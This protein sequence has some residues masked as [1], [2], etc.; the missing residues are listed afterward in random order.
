MAVQPLRHLGVDFAPV[1]VGERTARIVLGTDA[2]WR[3]R[4]RHFLETQRT[5][6]GIDRHQGV[7]QRRDR[8]RLHGEEIRR[9]IDGETYMSTNDYDWYLPLPQSN[10]GTQS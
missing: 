10:I 3:R 2:R 8:A 5:R 7:H 1:G 4:P 6:I 9:L